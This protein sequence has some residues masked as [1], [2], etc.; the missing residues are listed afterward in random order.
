MLFFS[1]V[2]ENCVNVCFTV[3]SIPVSKKKKKT[4]RS[5]VTW[6]QF[7]CVGLTR[8]QPARSSFPLCRIRS[9]SVSKSCQTK[10]ITIKATRP[11]A[12]LSH[13]RGERVGWVTG[14]RNICAQGMQLKQP[15]L[16][17]RRLPQRRS[18]WKTPGV[19]LQPA[20]VETQMQ[21]S[22][23]ITPTSVTRFLW[24]F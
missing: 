5:D 16:C 1:L 4:H 22:Q 18:P 9:K 23:Q 11:S 14:N 20:T 12:V 2:L 7:M 6:G 24:R 17:P 13:P 10:K 19:C 3:A 21:A 8:Q 15:E